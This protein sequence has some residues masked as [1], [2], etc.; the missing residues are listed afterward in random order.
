MRILVSARLQATAAPDAP[1]PMISTSTMS[2]RFAV[3]VR[4]SGHRATWACACARGRAATSR[5]APACALGEGRPWLE[6]E[7]AHYAVVAVIALQDHPPE[8]GAAGGAGDEGRDVGVLAKGRQFG[9]CGADVRGVSADRAD[10]VGEDERIVRAGDAVFLAGREQHAG[11]AVERVGFG[12][13]E[14]YRELGAIDRFS[15]R[16]SR[17]TSAS[18]RFVTCVLFRA[19]PLHQPCAPIDALEVCPCRTRSARF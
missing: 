10:D 8:C 18:F 6:P 4:W 13:G 7:R 17:L 1:E 14:C 2:L 12:G 16:P 19:Q 15:T 9:E 3:H 11:D 5:P